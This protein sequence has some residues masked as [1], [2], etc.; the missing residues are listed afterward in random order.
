M[1]SRNNHSSDKPPCART[2]LRILHPAAGRSQVFRCNSEKV[3]A[4]PP[5]L[6]N[7]RRLV[8]RELFGDLLSEM[9]PPAP[10]SRAVSTHVC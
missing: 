7:E 9:T 5:P 2:K 1:D 4:S 10:G 6:S 8:W 3:R